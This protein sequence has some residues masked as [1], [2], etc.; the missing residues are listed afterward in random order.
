[1]KLKWSFFYSSAVHL[2][3]K[4]TL[5]DLEMHSIAKE[6]GLSETAFIGN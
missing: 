6:L 1:M 3:V 5:S 2:L 4:G